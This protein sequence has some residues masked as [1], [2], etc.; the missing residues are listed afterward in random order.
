MKIQ[1][2]SNYSHLYGANRVLLTMLE[3]FSV[4][5]YDI[6]VL[7]P[8]NGPMSEELKKRNIPFKVSFFFSS[9]LYFKFSVKYLIFPV[10][11]LINLFKFFKIVSIVK[12]FNPD[13]IYSNT[14]AENF[15]LLISRVLNKPH[16]SHIHEFMQPDHG[17][18]FIGGNRL[19]LKYI[20]KSD[21][22][23]FVSNAVADYVMGGEIQSEK[24]MVIHNGISRSITHIS[25][26]NIS[27]EIN[28]G[29]VGI[30]SEGKNQH[31]A[32]EYFASLLSVY[33]TASL[34]VF[35]D[36]GGRYKSK[37]FKL[38]RQLNIEDKVIFH[39]FVKN[40][41]MIF[42]QFD[43]MLMFSKSEGFGIVTIEAMLRGVPV[44]GFNMAGTKELIVD[45][46][47]G[48]LFDSLDSFKDSIDYLLSSE[49][50][51]EKIRLNAFNN[52]L[53]Q[54]NELDFCKRIDAFII[55]TKYSFDN[56][57]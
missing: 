29:I 55:K 20:N 19:K 8:S 32:I 47:T 18:Y 26:K 50:I 14:S 34:H 12:E 24:H 39:G 11:L 51:Y 23:V 53:L 54:F 9:F 38:C 36:K 42:S 57:K 41:D 5:G 46:E 37:L 30:L 52:A 3:Y 27:K 21:G 56:I 28:L 48:C 1:F 25:P 15:G 44:V 49:A 31:L 22:V 10:L 35:G 2:I 7:L 16:I 17:A 13:I 6:S 45:R 4:N 33:P 40:T 43:V